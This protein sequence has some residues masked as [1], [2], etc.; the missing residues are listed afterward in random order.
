VYT[1]IR[2]YN[3]FPKT[4]EDFSLDV[5]DNLLPILR[6][7]PGFRAYYL[8]ETGANEAVAV[9]TFDSLADAK[10]AARLTMDWVGKH[11]EL[12]FQGFSK[13]L[14]G[15]VRVHCKSVCLS[16]TNGQE[17]PHTDRQEHMQGVF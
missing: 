5:Q 6:Q 13:P 8:L 9:S 3:I 12:Y 2:K 14:A 4:V 7:M 11:P 15:E 17:Q 16:H 1:V 10:V